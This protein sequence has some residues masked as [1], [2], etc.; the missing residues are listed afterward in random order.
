[1]NQDCALDIMKLGHNIFLTGEAGTG[2]TFILNK[3]IEYLRGHS[4]KVAV[5]ASTGIA[6]THINGQTIHSWCGIGIKTHLNRDDIL[7]ILRERR[8]CKNVEQASVL[9]IDEISM[10]H[11]DTID[12]IDTITKSIRN[13]TNPFGGLQ[14]VMC[15]DFFQLPPVSSNVKFAFESPAWQNAEFKICYLTDQKRQ[16]DD[17]LLRILKEIRS[18]AVSKE[19]ID[20][21]S[22]LK[23]N[24]SQFKTALF[25]KNINVDEY[26]ESN[27]NELPGKL[28]TFRMKRSGLEFR[29]KSLVKNC[30]AP[31]LLKVKMGAKVIF[32]KNSEDRSYVNGTL[33]EVVGYCDYGFP[34]VRTINDLDVKTKLAEWSYEENGLVRASIS[35]IPIRLAWALTIHKSQGMTLDAAKI[36]L[37]NA[38][39]AGMGYVALSRVK[40]LDNLQ[41]LGFNEMALRVNDKVICYDKEISTKTNEACLDYDNLTSQQEGVLLKRLNGKLKFKKPVKRKRAYSV[42]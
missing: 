18:N 36:D 17:G 22:S 28:N 25:T 35:Q 6:A 4:V 29:V 3:Y 14:V 15:G 40:T 38:F 32:V 24:E 42:F 26:N 1:M 13:N 21:L 23:G 2:K 33:G 34:I 16:S 10:L 12:A 37:S 19:S 20:I 30:L 27:L 31:D 9:I 39:E 11:A 8:I 7:R 41:L 5:T